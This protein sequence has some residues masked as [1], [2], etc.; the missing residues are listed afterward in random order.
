MADEHWPE[1]YAVTVDRPPWPTVLAA[2]DRF[3]EEDGGSGHD[4]HDGRG[5]SA[6]DLGCGAGR[7][8]R[9]ILRRGWRVLAID[10]EASAIETLRAATPEADLPRLETIVGDLDGVDVPVC[11]L[12]NA[13]ISLPF[14]TSD[15][16]W[17]TW[18]GALAAVASG[19][20]VSAML[21]GERD[22]S[23]DDP[24]MTCP[25]PDAIRETLAD[26]EIEHWSVTEEDGQTALG[27]PHHFQIIE[28]VARRR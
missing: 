20:R 2:L 21:F 11:D 7:D 14:L 16:Y 15:A 26:F 19:G 3:A 1:Y 13:S 17:R 12:V 25:P 6:V 24:T 23:A 4:G 27:E 9:E 10:R 22:E 5:R 28:V 18:A 8:A